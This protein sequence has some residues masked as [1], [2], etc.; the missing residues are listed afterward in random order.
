MEHLVNRS[1]ADIQIS[2]IRKISNLVSQYQDA[3][4]LTIGQPDFP[5][6]AHILE[7]GQRAIAGNKTGYTMNAGLIEL[8][9]AAAMFVQGKYGLLYDPKEEIIV[10]NGASEAVDT[11]LRTILGPDTEVVLPG[12]IYPGYEPIVR[13]CGATP[14]YVDTTGNDFKLTADLLEKVLTPKTRCV[15]LCYPSNPTGCVLSRDELADIARLLAD[16][17]IFVLSDEIYSELCFDAPH[18][19]IAS[20]PEMR[21]KTI[22]I[23]GLSKSHAMTGWRIG[24]TFAPANITR[25]MLKVHQ[26]N[27]TCASSI[28]QHAAIE[29]LTNGIDDALPMK[30][31]YA[32]RRDYVLQRLA[33]MGIDYVKPQGAFYVFPSIRRFDLSSMTFAMRLLEE[34]RVAVVP[35]DAF[36]SYGEGYI[37]ISYAYSM[38]VLEQAL[39]RMESFIQSIT[40]K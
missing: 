5:T 17:D 12:P 13:L 38:D 25:H 7:A 6:P 35:G 27:S 9:Q 32:T 36:S 33:T 4:T 26:Y 31:A 2:G 16:K 8:R 19:S 3:L 21:E 24:F 11:T 40:K 22:V 18:V 10:T 30:Q 1:V 28:S 15:V 37:R 39:D 14:V 20:F 29:A 23:N 34:R